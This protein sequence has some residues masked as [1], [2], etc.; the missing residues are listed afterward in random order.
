MWRGG[1][2]KVDPAAQLEFIIKAQME[3]NAAYMCVGSKSIPA[4]FRV[5]LRES[6]NH[7]CRLR[8]FT[9]NLAGIGALSKERSFA[10]DM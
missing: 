6:M 9:D 8:L 10:Y 4:R 1:E 5:V 2:G 3:Y 7:E